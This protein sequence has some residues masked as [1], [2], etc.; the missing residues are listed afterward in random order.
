MITFDC[1]H[2]NTTIETDDIYAGHKYVCPRCE[3]VI[4]VPLEQKQFD[5]A[6]AVQKRQQDNPEKATQENQPSNIMDCPDCGGKVSIHASACPH[7]GAPLKATTDNPTATKTLRQADYS[8][9]A[10]GNHPDALFEDDLIKCPSCGNAVST[11]ATFC[12]KCGRKFPTWEK[13]GIGSP[14]FCV[15]MFIIIAFIIWACFLHG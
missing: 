11:N 9:T 13:T 15:V 5:L 1:P 10:F 4:T 14:A 12:P 8:G 2:C 7:C 6:K 3:K